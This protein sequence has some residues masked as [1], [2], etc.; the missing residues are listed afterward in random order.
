LDALFP[1]ESRTFRS[2]QLE[3]FLEKI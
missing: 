2:N 1:Q 3:C